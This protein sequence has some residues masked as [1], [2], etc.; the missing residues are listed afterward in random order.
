MI[1]TRDLYLD[2]PES[3]LKK[4]GSLMELEAKKTIWVRN[5]AA[6]RNGI[7]NSDAL[8]FERPRDKSLPGC[9]LVVCGNGDGSRLYVPNI[10]PSGLDELD[11]KTYNRLLGEF[12]R[13]IVEPVADDQGFQ[14]ELTTKHVEDYDLFGETGARLLRTFSECANKSTGSG[15]PLDRKRWIQFLTEAHRYNGKAH[16]ADL[17]FILKQHGWPERHIN[18]LSREYEISMDILTFKNN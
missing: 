12:H 2:V 5:K 8:V 17:E 4:I 3:A 6:E 10:V 14:S 15:H 7:Y 1:V 16:S 11:I 13:L 18:N 9:T